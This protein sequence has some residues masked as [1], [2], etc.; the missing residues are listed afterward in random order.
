MAFTPRA[1]N[2]RARHDAFLNNRSEKC[3]PDP[4]V[5]GPLQPHLLTTRTVAIGGSFGMRRL[6]V[7]LSVAAIALLGLAAVAGPAQAKYPGPNGQV[8]FSRY[9][10]TTGEPHIFIANPDGTHEHQLPLP[11]PG[12]GAVW[13][14]TG[15]RLLVMVFRPDAPVRPATVNADGSGFTVLAVPQLPPDID[16]GCRVW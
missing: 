9:D 1:T 3:I 8:A 2:E 14:P 13:S 16:M 15:D 6:I 11:L 4:G 10:P 12:D 5:A 7:L